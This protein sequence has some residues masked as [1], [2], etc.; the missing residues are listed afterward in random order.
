[1]VKTLLLHKGYVA[2]QTAQG[3]YGSVAKTL[4]LSHHSS[5]SLK[6]LHYNQNGK[7]LAQ[8]K[9]EWLNSIK[10]ELNQYQYLLVSDAD[11]FKILT[12]ESKAETNLGIIKDSEFTTA[13][14]L[15]IPPTHT[16]KYDLAKFKDKVKTTF[17]T[18]ISHTTGSYK[19]IGS[20]IVQSA[21]YPM[22][23]SE[24][25][26][27]LKQ[28]HS[29]PELAVDIEA[30]SLKLTDAGI[31]TIAFAWDEHN[32]IAFPVDIATEPDKVRTLLKDFFDTY[33]G[34]LIVHK[35]NYDIPILVYNLYMGLDFNNRLGQLDGINTLCRNLDDTLLI[36][37][38]STNSCAGN[39]LG[40]KQLAQPFAG[41]WA[42][43]VSDVT[44][45]ELKTLLRYNLI[46]VL[47][48]FYI[49]N[50][51]YPLL[52][53]ENQEQLYREHFLPY[54]RDCIRMQLNGL[55]INLDKVR[56]LEAK[57]IQEKNQLLGRINNLPAIK[58]AEQINASI[59]ANKRN[60]KYK[61]KRVSWKDC[62]E[63][64]NYNSNQ[65]LEI[66]LYEVMQLPVIETTDSGNPS[67]SGSTL[68]N[69]IN[70]T[71]NTQYQLILKTISEYNDV[72]KILTGFIPAFKN[73][74]V[75]IHGNV[76]LSGYFNLGGTVSGRM[77]SNSPNLQN[78]PATGSRFAKL[79][80]ECFT[81]NDYWLMCGIDFFSLEDRIS[82]LTTKD[83][84]KLDVYLKGYDG[85]CLRAY[86]YFKSQMP[87]IELA[88]DSEKCYSAKVGQSDIVWKSSDTIH[89][90]GQSYTGDEFYE[91]V[92]SKKL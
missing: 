72:E 86:S 73:A 11:Y 39:T 85:H 25:E 21:S 16:A 79:V 63:P 75:D 14:I 32:G 43:D 70:H 8:E 81:S 62:Y 66:L 17:S 13:K 37:Y 90:Q 46:D 9:K 51:Y 69:L 40:L 91:M 56:E 33:Q 7:T 42:V 48:T 67:V 34:K 92:A 45:V 22:T 44:K 61:K 50:K 38:L 6:S 82:A 88:E 52:I 49:K 29:Y 3:L 24:I 19:E 26:L 64:F 30:K 87:D 27:A 76:R 54:L 23:A 28:L 53:K 68:E 20:D 77:S 41:N 55:P 5:L 10:D 84:F 47:S 12:K 4:N 89:Y 78:L 74:T 71:T 15:Y 80:K 58:N 2:V 60:E 59:K 65:Q 18:L 36:T 83:P 57:L 31:Y 1:M 35:G